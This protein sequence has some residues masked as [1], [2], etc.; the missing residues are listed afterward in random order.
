[1]EDQGNRLEQPLERAM[2]LELFMFFVWMVETP[3]WETDLL[4]EVFLF[5]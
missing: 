1:M 4:Y 2:R 5:Y 3:A